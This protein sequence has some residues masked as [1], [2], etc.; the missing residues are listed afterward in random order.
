MKITNVPISMIN[1]GDKIRVNGCVQ[2]VDLIA[3]AALHGALVLTLIPH[4]TMLFNTADYVA[5][6][7]E[8]EDKPVQKFKRGCRVKV[9]DVMPRHMSHFIAGFE[10]IVEYTY[11]QEYGGGHIKSYSLIVLKD[12]KPVNTSAWY[13]ESQLTLINADTAA[14]LAIIEAYKYPS[15]EGK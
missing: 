10:G 8:E 7:V 9:D 2:T 5:R 11:A 14:G 4:G 3:K 15:L 13:D 12:G 1:A 6:V